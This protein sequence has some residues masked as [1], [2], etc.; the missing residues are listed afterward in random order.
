MGGSPYSTKGQKISKNKIK[1][2]SAT[3]K[4]NHD[5]MGANDQRTK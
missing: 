1:K 5:K 4:C 3:R 2:T